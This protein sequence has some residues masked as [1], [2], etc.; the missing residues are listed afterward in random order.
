MS[1][2]SQTLLRRHQRAAHTRSQPVIGRAGLRGFRGGRPGISPHVSPPPV[3]FSSDP[4]AIVTVQVKTIIAPTPNTYQQ[5]GCF[6]SYGATT[7]NPNEVQELTSRG[8]LDMVND[9][10]GNLVSIAHP[11]AQIESLTWAAGVVTATVD[12]AL[13]PNLQVGYVSITGCVPHA[14]N[15]HHTNATVIDATTFTYPLADDPGPANELG[16]VGKEASIE[17]GQMAT[18][19]FDQGNAISVYVLEL[20]EESDFERRATLLEKWLELNPRS[21]YGYLLPRAHGTSNEKIDYFRNLF[22]QYQNPEAMTYFWMTVD[23]PEIG[24]LDKT[25]KC[26]IQGVEAPD[27]R[28]DLNLGDPFGEFTLASMFY[29]A[30]IY[31]PSNA[32]RISPM[33]FKFAYGVT[34]YPT[35]N[36]GPL[37][38][39]FKDNATNYIS[40]G[41]EGGIDFNMI[42]SGVTKDG[43]DYFNWWWTIDWV[44]IA[45]NLDLSNCIINGANDALA[46]LYYDQGGI[47]TLHA[48][49]TGTMINA[50]AFGM[51]VGPIV[52]S[53]ST[54]DQLEQ[55]IANG[56]YDGACNTNAVPFVPYAQS[57]PGHYKIGEYDG[58]STLF[59]PKRGFIHVLVTVAA[60]E[61]VVM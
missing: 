49:L 7:L 2:L 36:N 35:Q 26:V 23:E 13:P 50:R 10:S 6:V 9:G 21:F 52:M 42:Y 16:T 56:V 5:T 30:M 22:K 39:S 48:C 38:K 33:A 8:D 11:S 19:F 61:L 32:R 1:G 29:N 45:V 34:P 41:A 51:V 28:E 44:Q 54:G 25:Y 60:S 55:D 4:N 46:P 37:L 3:H 14:Y 53:G 58:L 20:G 24:F 31:K 18:T 43:M 40:T 27:V 17:L 15:V 57:N 47:D 59:I 12:G